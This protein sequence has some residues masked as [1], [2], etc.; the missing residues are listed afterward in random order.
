MLKHHT[1]LLYKTAGSTTRI[2]LAQIGPALQCTADYGESAAR[3]YGE[4]ST[5]ETQQAVHGS[6]TENDRSTENGPRRR[7][8]VRVPNDVAVAS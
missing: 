2:I 5:A 8:A 6:C 3:Q 4:M 1:S 7:S